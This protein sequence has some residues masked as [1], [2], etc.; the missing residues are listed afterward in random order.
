[1][2][3]LTGGTTT[4]GLSLLSVGFNV[5]S[6]S[7]VGTSVGALV[8]YFSVGVNVGAAVVGSLVK[9]FSVGLMVG[10]DDGSSVGAAVVGSRV[11]LKV[12]ED[13]GS[14]VGS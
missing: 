10:E 9:S 1:M 8:K 4:V 3:D 14:S 12:G 6:A 7:L 13:D 5:L 11:G 2:G